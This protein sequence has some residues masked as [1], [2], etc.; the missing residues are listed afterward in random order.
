MPVKTTS[1]RPGERVVLYFM[2][3]FQD[4]DLDPANARELIERDPMKLFE[5]I[6]INVEKALGRISDVKVYDVYKSR[7]GVLVE[8]L[9]K[10]EVG[11][12]S[13]RVIVGENPYK[14]LFDYYRYEQSASE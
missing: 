11:E 12:L 4:L 3:I 6:R 9:V 8:Y 10:G 5:K 14:V 1:T 13:A 7:H 2:D